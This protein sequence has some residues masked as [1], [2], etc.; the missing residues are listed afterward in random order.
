MKLCRPTITAYN[1]APTPNL[2]HSRVICL[3]IRGLRYISDLVSRL[4]RECW[5]V[6]R[7][8]SMHGF[9]CSNQPK[10]AKTIHW[11]G[12]QMKANGRQ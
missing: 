11:F 2:L 1:N 3:S 12:L 7:N 4:R 8:A 9:S 5:T 10:R 6:G